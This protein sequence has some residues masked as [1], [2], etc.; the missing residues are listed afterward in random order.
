MTGCS[1]P[2]PRPSG[3]AGWWR[4]AGASTRSSRRGGR[5]VRLVGAVRRGGEG[6]GLWLVPAHASGLFVPARSGCS[7]PRGSATSTVLADPVLVPA[8]AMLGEGGGGADV[9]RG[10]VLPW[11]AEFGA[12][13]AADAG[14]PLAVS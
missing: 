14:V 4:C 5:H 10:V 1:R 6:L 8:E 9:L 2:A 3:A 13:K 11:L 12:A 7:G